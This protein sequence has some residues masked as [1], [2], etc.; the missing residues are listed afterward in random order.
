MNELDQPITDTCAKCLGTGS[1]DH[2]RNVGSSVVDADGTQRYVPKVCFNCHGKGTITTTQRTINHRQADRDQRQRKRAEADRAAAEE[3]AQR[4]AAQ[5]AEFE[6][7]NPKVIQALDET[8]GGFAEQMRTRLDEHGSLTTKQAEAILRIVAD[9]PTADCPEG[10]VT[11]TGEITSAKIVES[12]YGTTVKITLRDDRGFKVHGNLPKAL[13]EIFWEAYHYEGA[14]QIRDTGGGMVWV[15]IVTGARVRFTATVT[16]G[17]QRGFGFYKR[18][19]K[20]ELVEH[21]D[22]EAWGDY[23]SDGKHRDHKK[24]KGHS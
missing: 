18:P 2:G 4:I 5:R 19:A 12:S 21:S 7:A 9:A 23:R 13:D 6:A 3:K 10:R 14:E 15:R 24:R 20:A 1:V 16:G 22:S 17:D 11:L 8:S